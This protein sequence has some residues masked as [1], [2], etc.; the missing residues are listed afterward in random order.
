[1]KEEVKAE[2]VVAN[3]KDQ[4]KAGQGESGRLV[5]CGRQSF[6]LIQCNAACPYVHN[7]YD[8]EGVLRIPYVV[9]IR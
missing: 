9:R 7:T 6:Q 8:T 3:E 2:E 1:M 5:G 4:E